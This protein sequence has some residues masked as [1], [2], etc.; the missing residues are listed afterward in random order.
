MLDMMTI[1]LFV[2]AVISLVVAA[3][4]IGWISLVSSRLSALGRKV[5]AS[6]DIGRVIQAADKTDSFESRLTGCKSKADESQNQLA[7]LQTKLSEI[8]V[9][10]GAF[11]QMMDRLTTDLT[12]TSEK[13]A[14]F[15]LRFDG[16]ENDFR[17]KLNQLLQF[18]TKVNEL[19]SNLRSIEGKVNNNGS[20]LAQAD[21]SIKALTD[22]IESLKEFQTTTEK[23]HRL[24]QAA[25]TDTR[26]SMP[27]EE[28]L[29]IT[30]ET[31]RLEETL[32]EPEVEQVDE[33]EVEQV[34]EPEVEQVD[35]PEV[36]QVIEHEVQHEDEQEVEQEEAE[37]RKTPR[38]YRFDL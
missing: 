34:D 11:G 7:E 26:T 24:L 29:S 21:R 5:L 36:E 10:L 9:K 12:T 33:H 23:T 38:T 37:D 27:H 17:E 28:G 31:A 13:T 22:E 6:E 32:Q 20:G 3:V 18:E 4:A 30:S 16:F 2:L 15:E 1:A 35:E 14:S 25:F 19:A 8:A